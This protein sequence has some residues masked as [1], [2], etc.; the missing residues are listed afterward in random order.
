MREDRGG[1]TGIPCFPPQ[2]FWLQAQRQE[3]QAERSALRG[4]GGEAGV[5][6]GE[7]EGWGGRKGSRAGRGCGG[8]AQSLCRD[9]LASLLGTSP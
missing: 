2:G 9:C 4:A 8:S 3:R 5:E 1:A 6:R 7:A